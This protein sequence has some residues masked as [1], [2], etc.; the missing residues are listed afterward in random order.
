[1]EVEFLSNM[2]YLLFTTGQQWEEWHRTLSRFYEFFN[3][4]PQPKPQLQ[5]I[6][7]PQLLPS[8]PSSNNAS[9]PLLASHSPA[10]PYMYTMPQ[11]NV[12]MPMSMPLPSP[13][14]LPPRKRSLED[15]EMSMPK[16]VTRSMATLKYPN[17]P[18]NG[19]TSVQNWAG[20]VNSNGVN[21][22]S[23]PPLQ[24]I[25]GYITSLPQ[26]G[27]AMAT[28]YGPNGTVV[29]GSNTPSTRQTT[30]VSTPTSTRT[31]TQSVNI[32]PFNNS[33]RPGSLYAGSPASVTSGPWT[34]FNTSSPSYFLTNRESPYRPVRRVNALLAP[35]PQQQQQPPL[36][37]MENMQYL[38]LAKRPD[39]RMGQVPYEL[40][41]N[42]QLR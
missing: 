22:S 36:V 40:T 24:L 42:W 15:G 23:M 4:A 37:Q 27:R 20:M 19:Y 34:P 9:P 5:A 8:P 29:R 1:M 28:A 12:A 32:S 18:I 13:T 31:M 14:E 17:I 38:P 11:Q 7:I 33:S 6:K 2:R 3:R 21:P 30:L 39:H 35:P 25:N 10:N 41:P 16:R 26:P